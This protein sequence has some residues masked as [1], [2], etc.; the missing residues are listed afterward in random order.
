MICSPHMKTIHPAT[1][2]YGP[3]GIGVAL[4]RPFMPSQIE[5]MIAPTS[6]DS[7]IVG[8]IPCS[9]IHAPSAASSLKSP[10]PMPSLPVSCLNSHH[11]VH[12]LR[13]PIT[14]PTSA[15]LARSEEHTSELQALMRISYAVF[16]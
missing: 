14:A 4:S 16:C 5:P 3:N 6:D 15:G 2:R 7:R 9:P 8:N 1:A 11:T 13:Y 12:R 10:W